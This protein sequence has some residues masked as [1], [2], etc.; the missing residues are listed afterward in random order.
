VTGTGDVSDL[1]GKRAESA[2]HGGAEDVVRCD[3]KPANIARRPASGG[4]KLK[5]FDV[6]RIGDASRR[7]AAAVTA[8]TPHLPRGQLA[9][10]KVDAGSKPSVTISHETT[11]GLRLRGAP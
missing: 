8:A 5:D 6:A 4:V 3:S 9:G 1:A 11:G 7:R 10:E 2:E